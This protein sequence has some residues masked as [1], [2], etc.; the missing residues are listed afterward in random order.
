MTNVAQYIKQV[1]TQSPMDFSS[2]QAATGWLVQSL[3]NQSKSWMRAVP[4]VHKLHEHVAL[5]N[6]HG[7]D[8]LWT[9]FSRMSIAVLDD[10]VKYEAATLSSGTLLAM[11]TCDYDS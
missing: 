10:F 8:R 3:S 9:V 7:L 4:H 5:T 6:G 2:A 11:L 1:A